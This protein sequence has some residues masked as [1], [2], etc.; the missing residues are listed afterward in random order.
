L[1]KDMRE[2]K[3]DFFLEVMNTL[4]NKAG[5]ILLARWSFSPVYSSV[6]LNHQ[7]ISFSDKPET[8]VVVV[9]FANLFVRGLGFSLKDVKE[10]DLLMSKS[11]KL[12]GLNAE[13]LE[14]VTGEVKE[15]VEKVSSIL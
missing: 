9:H 11:A 13:I 15:Y 6:A 4:H 8:E 14:K 10:E 5:S 7:D 1:T 3:L 12:L 2:M